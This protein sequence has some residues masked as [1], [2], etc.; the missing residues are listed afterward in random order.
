MSAD[1]LM[2]LPEACGER[3]C[4]VGWHVHHVWA[5]DD[6]TYSICDSDG[7]HDDLDPSDLPTDDEYK[8]AWHEYHQHVASTGEDPLNEFFIPRVIKRRQKWRVRIVPSISGPLAASFRRGGRW[9]A[10]DR[11]TADVVSYLNLD[12]KR[13]RLRD[14]ARWEDLATAG[15]PMTPAGWHDFTL[16]VSVPRSPR[17]LA[18]DLRRAAR[19]AMEGNKP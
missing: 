15:V 1:I 6:G 17:A 9:I 12:E 8:T 16:E 5:Y 13:R 7:N 4:P 14:F 18:R 3:G 19:K 10:R 2:S 11:L